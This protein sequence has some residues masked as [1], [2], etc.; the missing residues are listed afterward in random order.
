MYLLKRNTT[1][2]FTIMGF[3]IALLFTFVALPI[4]ALVVSIWAEE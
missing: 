2:R 3:T 1:K 4:A